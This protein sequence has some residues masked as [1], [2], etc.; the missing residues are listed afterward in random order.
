M[1]FD[2][3][4]SGY[5]YSVAKDIQC[6][7]LIAQSIYHNSNTPSPWTQLL[8]LCRYPWDTFKITMD[9][10]EP[11]LRSA[12]TSLS[13]PSLSYCWHSPLPAC[14]LTPHFSS[15]APLPAWVP[16]TP[17]SKVTLDGASEE[18]GAQGVYLRQYFSLINSLD[19]F[20]RLHLPHFCHSTVS[21][22]S[23][24]QGNYNGSA[25]PLLVHC[26]HQLSSYSLISHHLKPTW[27]RLTKDL[28][29]QL[30]FNPQD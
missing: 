9:R 30:Q 17:V 11:K 24:I 4:D 15:L 29:E 16:Q 7:I 2:K 13:P 18:T 10:F 14:L 6:Q 25:T 27:I 20:L 5:T 8:P 21:L 19:Q 22:D 12:S 1:I 28:S 23:G 3:Y 26:Q